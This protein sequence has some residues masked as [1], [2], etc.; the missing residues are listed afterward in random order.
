MHYKVC[1]QM[2]IVVGVIWVR[3]LR[4]LTLRYA[5]FRKKITLRVVLIRS[6]VCAICVP[7]C[8]RSGPE[9]AGSEETR[10]VGREHL[11]CNSLSYWTPWTVFLLLYLEFP[12]TCVIKSSCDLVTLVFY[13]R[14]LLGCSSQ[15]SLLRAASFRLFLRV[16]IFY[17][18]MTNSGKDWIILLEKSTWQRLKV[19]CKK[20]LDAKD[21]GRSKKSGRK[22]QQKLLT[23][24]SFFSP[25]HFHKHRIN[26][27]ITLK[28]TLENTLEITLEITLPV[29]N[30]SKIHWQCLL[31]WKKKLIGVW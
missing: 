22:S 6:L 16:A 8:L 13:A 20:A 12:E 25:S 21:A 1:Y 19:V 7:G 14:L 10:Q 9:L 30:L 23:P 3:I 28:I 31:E 5:C 24:P 15:V 2:P 4:S 26:I 27:N 17:R 29:K 11:K 18:K